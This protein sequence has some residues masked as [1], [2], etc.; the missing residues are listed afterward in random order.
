[1]CSNRW[2]EKWQRKPKYLEKTLV[3]T[4]LSTTNPT[5]RDMGSKLGRR[6]GKPVTIRLN[7]GRAQE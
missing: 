7:Y 5:W 1:M 2:D 4:I 3:G 6:G